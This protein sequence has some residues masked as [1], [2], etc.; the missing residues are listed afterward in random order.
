M[1][2]RFEHKYAKSCY[3]RY[4]KAEWGGFRSDTLV[5]VANIPL[6]PGAEGYDEAKVDELDKAVTQYVKARHSPYAN[7]EFVQ[8]E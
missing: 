8:V 5:V 7:I 3:V 2:S 1:V 4:K 6:E